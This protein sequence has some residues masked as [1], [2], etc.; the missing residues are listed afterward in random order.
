MS[1]F[2]SQSNPLVQR[3]GITK[4]AA[5]ARPYRED[6]RLRAPVAPAAPR[7]A[8][9][10]RTRP[11]PTPPT[12]DRP[13]K[14][15]PAPTPDCASSTTHIH[16]QSSGRSPA[17]SDTRLN[18]PRGT[19][20]RSRHSPKV[21]SERRIDPAG[22]ERGRPLGRRARNAREIGGMALPCQAASAGC[23]AGTKIAARSMAWSVGVSRALVVVVM[24]REGRRADSC[25]GG[26][27]G[28]E[29]ADA[30]RREQEPAQAPVTTLF[31]AAT[32]PARSAPAAGRSETAPDRRR[33]R[34][35]A[36]RG[37]RGCTGPIR[38]RASDRS[39]ASDSCA[40]R[41][42]MSSIDDWTSRWNVTM[43]MNAS[44]G[45]R[46]RAKA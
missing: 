12:A 4:P 32:I 36:G 43:P 28:K 3:P 42:R 7:S 15:A 35:D 29:R 26:D 40:A 25:S 5:C 22:R 10:S 1:A 2:A 41:T 23:A 18:T 14:P 13:G 8:P 45:R 38:A 6:L 11:P 24:D 33:R 27:G 20:T 19:R 9:A 44:T 21:Q 46:M 31:T 17:T 37:R 16:P 30:K 39:P 34:L